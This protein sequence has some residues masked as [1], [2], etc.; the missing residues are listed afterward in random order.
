MR[1]E[2]FQFSVLT[3]SPSQSSASSV[4]RRMTSIRRA[5][6]ASRQCVIALD[7]QSSPVAR[8]C[9][10]TRRPCSTRGLKAT[11]RVPRIFTS[12][13]AEASAA[14]ARR[15]NGNDRRSRILLVAFTPVSEGANTTAFTCRLRRRGVF[16]RWA[17]R[18]AANFRRQPR[19]YP[20]S[21]YF[22]PTSW[23]RRT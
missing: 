14:L 5:F 15:R 7:P 2:F 3:C 22:G 16:S 17:T 10:S 11:R 6:E 20:R 12:I 9:L 1:R 8:R 21:T 4:A 18:L 13:F 23:S 19:S